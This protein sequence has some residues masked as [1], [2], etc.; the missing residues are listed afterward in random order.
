MDEDQVKGTKIR[1][2]FWTAI[3]VAAV[4]WGGS[5]VASPG[6]RVIGLCCVRVERGALFID[7]DAES[8]MPRFGN[9]QRPY[10]RM[11]WIDGFPNQ[12]LLDRLKDS[13]WV[14]RFLTTP[15]TPPLPNFWLGII[16]IWVLICGIVG[17]FV[18]YRTRASKSCASQC[19]KC[20]YPRQ[21]LAVNAPCPE[22]GASPTAKVLSEADTVKM[23]EARP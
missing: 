20:E 2:A 21:G 22:C 13:V 11:I 6:F 15:A 17:M 18:V 3:L 10:V 5:F 19:P 12:K 7:P 14:P 4:F 8:K 1:I 23:Q 16:P 9:V